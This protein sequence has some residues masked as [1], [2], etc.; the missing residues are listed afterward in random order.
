MTSEL[1][2]SGDNKYTAVLLCSSIGDSEDVQV[3]IRWSPDMEG[4][5]V[6]KLGYLPASYRFLQD[7]ILPALE[8]AFTEG[9]DALE[10]PRD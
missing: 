1:Q 8:T 10:T 5:D 2:S 3:E 6:Q 9:L 4:T 7:F